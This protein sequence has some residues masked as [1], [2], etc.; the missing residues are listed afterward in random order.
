MPLRIPPSGVWYEVKLFGLLRRKD[1][2]GDQIS[3]RRGFQ[4]RFVFIPRVDVETFRAPTSERRMSP[5]F[6]LEL[7]KGTM[8]GEL[9]EAVVY[10]ITT[11]LGKKAVGIPGP[12]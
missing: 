6:F 11:P 4:R 5:A 1:A 7:L 9:M 12:T 2:L 8:P 10:R 3:Y